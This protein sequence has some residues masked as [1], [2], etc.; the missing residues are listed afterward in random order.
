MTHSKK[1]RSAKAGLPP[2]TPVHIGEQRTDTTRMLVLNYNEVEIKEKELTTI[3]ECIS[4]MAQDTTTWITI[5]GIHQ[6][7][8]L[9]HLATKLNLHPLVLEDLVNTE[10]RPKL[11]DHGEYLFFVLKWLTI[12]DTRHLLKIEQVSIILGSNFVISFQEGADDKFRSVRELL[13]HGKGR[14]RRLGSD[15]LA[16]ALLDTTVDHY[17]SVLESLGEMIESLETDLVTC[18]SQ[19]A[20]H[21]LHRLKREM[22]LL[23]N[24]VWPVREL[25]SGLE[26]GGS[27]LIKDSSLI[28][29][30]DVYDHTVQII[31]TTETFRD[32]LAGMLDLYLTGLSNKLNETMKILTIIATVFIPLTFIAGV[33][34]MNFKYM[35]E[36]EWRWGYPLVLLFM[37]ICAGMMVRYFRKRKWF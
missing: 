26:R 25:V 33:Y 27:T 8:I 6:I 36:L 3:E 37:G 18:P 30:R 1:K 31:D 17:F 4:T 32:M 2:G 9:N 22:I 28:Y 34:G 16:Y 23:R 10:Q 5:Q 19:E 29:L 11:E 7:E 35:P 12:P 24:T 13:H 14:I 21:L 20:L 15:Y